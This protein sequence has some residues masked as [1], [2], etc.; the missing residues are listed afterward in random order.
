MFEYE[1]NTRVIQMKMFFF[2]HNLLTQCHIIA[3]FFFIVSIM[4]DA[5]H[6]VLTNCMDPCILKNHL[7]K[8]TAT[9][10]SPVASVLLT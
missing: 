8:F 1:G 3:S 7:V 5:G 6:L 2:L 9:Y 4:F 10:A